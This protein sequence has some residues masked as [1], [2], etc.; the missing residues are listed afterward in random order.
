[1]KKQSISYVNVSKGLVLVYVKMPVPFVVWLIV[2][3]A[4]LFRQTMGFARKWGIGVTIFSIMIMVVVQPACV[5]AR[6]EAAV[7]QLAAR[8]SVVYGR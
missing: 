4:K 7:G 8:K 1:M 2:S 5:S 3:L 6:V